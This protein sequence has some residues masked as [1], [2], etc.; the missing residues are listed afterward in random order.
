MEV[1]NVR[2]GLSRRR[3]T[4]LERC[5]RIGSKRYWGKIDASRCAAARPI[6]VIVASSPHVCSESE[7]TC[8]FMYFLKD[9][10]ALS[11]AALGERL[12]GRV[13]R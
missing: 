2:D 3:W 7:L 6:D 11:T 4:L 9:H 8:T 1:W 13:R 10:A 12:Q 5:W